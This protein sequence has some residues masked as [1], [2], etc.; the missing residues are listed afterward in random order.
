MELASRYWPARNNEIGKI[1]LLHGMGGTGALWRPI[2]AGLEERISVL[3]LD[4]RGHGESRVSL[5]AGFSPLDYGRDVAE[6]LEARSFSPAVIVG[7]SMGARSACALV[8]LRPDLVRGL[9]LVD[10]GFEG[11]A[12]GGLGQTLASFLRILPMT[13]PDRAQAR[14]FM[15]EKCPDPAIAQYLMAV[16]AL[17]PSG[18]TGVTFPFQKDALIATIEAAENADLR[19]WIRAAAGKNI[20]VLALRGAASTVWSKEDFERERRDFSDLTHVVFEEWEGTGHGLPF[21]Q[22]ARFTARLQ[23]FLIAAPLR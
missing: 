1:A 9:V 22:R 4:Q 21:E 17:G 12:G 7:H 11:P 18:S 10:L 16:L 15:N 5:P 8:Q 23:E 13:F 19:L 6:T 14:T 20:P 2:A 3:A